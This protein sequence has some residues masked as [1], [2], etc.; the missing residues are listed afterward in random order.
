MIHED[1]IQTSRTL[2]AL[3]SQLNEA[4]KGAKTMS[5]DSKQIRKYENSKK[6][7]KPSFRSLGHGYSQVR[8]KRFRSEIQTAGKIELKNHICG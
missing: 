8:C 1:I 5:R 6:E 3:A 7:K 2:K 4:Q